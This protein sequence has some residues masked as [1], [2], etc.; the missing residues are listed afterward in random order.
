MRGE[1]EDR[2]KESAHARGVRAFAFACLA[3]H[4]LV[5]HELGSPVAVAAL[6]A[7][8]FALA[9]AIASAT[10]TEV[11][12]AATAEV[13][14]TTATEAATATAAAATATEAATATAAAATEAATATAAAAAATEA[15]TRTRSAGLSL[16]DNKGATLEVL[17]V[18]VLDRGCARFLRTHGHEAE[19]ARATGFAIRTNEHV[20]HFSMRR[21]DF[22][23]AIWRRTI[24]EISN[25][26]L[27][28]VWPPRPGLRHASKLLRD[29][30]D[31]RRAVD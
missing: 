13:A 25:K 6:V 10:A 4:L 12:T 24:V 11:A 9:I 21:K 18:E 28:H 30:C 31:S 14:T 3:P 16:V 5:R 15:A 2:Q 27:E 26:D 29:H 23:K 22:A 19:A 8:T 7:T 20:Q 17:T 1:R